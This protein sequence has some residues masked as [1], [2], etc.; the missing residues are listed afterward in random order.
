[1]PATLNN[2][3]T[4]AERLRDEAL[5]R[6]RVA[7][8]S[9]RRLQLQTGQL[10]AYRD[11]YR[12]RGPAAGGRSTTIDMLRCHAEFMQRLEQALDQQLAST[13]RA[14]AQTTRLR[15]ALVAEEVRVA[16]VRK[17]AERRLAERDLAATRLDQR[18]SD[19]SALQ[20]A[21]RQSQATTPVAG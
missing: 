18:R 12:Q 9:A 6:V 3:L 4:H 14:E 17:L 13:A 15:Q 11:E 10:R 19:E 8:E 2:L 1:M 21:W 7:E 16:S 20:S 5:A